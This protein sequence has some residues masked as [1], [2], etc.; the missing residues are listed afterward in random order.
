MRHHGATYRDYW[1]VIRHEKPPTCELQSRPCKPL[2]LAHGCL[3]QV[4][5]RELLGSSGY[6]SVPQLLALPILFCAWSLDTVNRVWEQ[7]MLHLYES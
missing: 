1:E 2:K 3:I 6:R 7:L 4:L 5:H